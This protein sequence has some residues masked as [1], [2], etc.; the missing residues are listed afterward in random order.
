MSKKHGGKLLGVCHLFFETGTEGSFWA[1]QDKKHIRIVDRQESWSYQ[2]LHILSDGDE[3]TIYNKKDPKKVVWSGIIQLKSYPVFTESA[4]N[5]WIH[6]DQI[7]IPRNTWA[8]WFMDEYPA[9]LIKA[10]R[11]KLP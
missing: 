1:F 6:S 4:Y 2:G 9:K 10:K 5:L 7:G 3:L 8:K 11:K